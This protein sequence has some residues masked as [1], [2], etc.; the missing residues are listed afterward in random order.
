MKITIELKNSKNTYYIK[1]EDNS[2][3]ND[4]LNAIENKKFVNIKNY[5]YNTYIMG[6][7]FIVNNNK[8]N[9]DRYIETAIIKEIIIR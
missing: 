5:Y 9:N 3:K 1:T 2:I 6:E 8:I 4:L 7:K